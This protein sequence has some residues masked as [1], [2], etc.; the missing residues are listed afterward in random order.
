MLAGLPFVCDNVFVQIL[1]F[2]IKMLKAFVQK[3]LLQPT[4]FYCCKEPRQQSGLLL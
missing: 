2:G 4:V 3:P 1:L